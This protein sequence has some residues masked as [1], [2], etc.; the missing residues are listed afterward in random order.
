MTV[1]TIEFFVDVPEELDN[2]KLR[3]SKTSGTRNVLF[4][5]KRL[6]SLERFK[7][8]TQQTYGDLRLTDEEGII[9]IQPSSTK[10]IFGGD[11]GDDLLRVECGFEIE[12]DDHWERFIRF[13]NRYAE[14]NG[15][16]YQASS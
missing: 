4:I 14:S 10:F 2:V 11:E 15:M 7:S 5:F 3:R 1:P 6:N 9:S 13:M 12:P 8:F 16:G